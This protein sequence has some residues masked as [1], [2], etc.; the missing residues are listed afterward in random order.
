SIGMVWDF[1]PL[2]PNSQP[3]PFLEARLQSCWAD[4]ASPRPE[5]AID[6][7]YNLASVGDGAVPFLE[8]KLASQKQKPVPPHV[9]EQLI[10]N[11]DSEE[12]P[13]RQQAVEALARIADVGFP[14]LQKAAIDHPSPEVRRQLE[15]LLLHPLRHRDRPDSIRIV[16][17]I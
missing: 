12:F 4:F 8:G 13:V 16:R 2:C 1:S 7:V 15:Q 6:A 11:L 5:T 9:I 3:L 17:S 14:A 10:A